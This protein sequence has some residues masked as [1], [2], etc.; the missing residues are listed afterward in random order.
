MQALSS[1][2][3]LSALVSGGVVSGGL[4]SETTAF[5]M[6]TGITDSNQISAI[7]TLVGS[8]I[9]QGIWGKLLA[10]YPFV[11]GNSIAHRFNLKDPRDL[12]VAF[13][14]SFVGTWIHSANGVQPDLNNS[15]YANTFFVPNT[16]LAS[17]SNAHH[18]VYIRQPS[19]AG[20]CDYGVT[21][22]GNEFTLYQNF[23]GSYYARIND[24]GGAL[25]TSP[26]AS[27]HLNV[28]SNSSQITV[29]DR[30]VGTNYNV[31]AAARPN[32]PVFFGGFNNN[33]SPATFANGVYAF[34]SLGLALDSTEAT[35]YYNAIQAFQTALGRAI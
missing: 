1:L 28:R 16:A 27:W 7:D 29:Y 32:L 31:N 22:S 12:D 35:N 24:G 18:G 11:G 26:G 20:R 30:A 3:G 25:K 34:F 13:R 14:L 21:A 4:R 2:S 10:C 6:A 15:A 33:G 9:D 19:L 8:L 5:L 23:G 17:I